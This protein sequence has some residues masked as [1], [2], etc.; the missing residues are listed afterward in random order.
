[1]LEAIPGYWT[2]TATGMPKAR[3]MDLP[4]AGG[5]GGPRLELGERLHSGDAEL[6]LESSLDDSEVDRLGLA[7]ELG[8]DLHRLGGEQ[9][10]RVD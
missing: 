10:A 1:M 4:D 9:V 7:L 3:A 5:C 8:E 6:L 2:F